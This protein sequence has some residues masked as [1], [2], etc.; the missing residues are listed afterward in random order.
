[1]SNTKSLA[2]NIRTKKLGLIIRN[3]R[4][5][6]AKSAEECAQAMGVSTDTFQSYESGIVS[7]SLPEIELLA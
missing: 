4:Q 2:K 6:Y 1:M 7:P 5:V 3:A